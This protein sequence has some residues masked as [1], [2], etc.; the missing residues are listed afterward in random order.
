MLM[1]VNMVMFDPGMAANWF[2]SLFQRCLPCRQTWKTW[3][4]WFIL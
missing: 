1:L 3:S 2:R 4:G